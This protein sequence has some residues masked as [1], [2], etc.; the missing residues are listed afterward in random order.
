M[1]YTQLHHPFKGLIT[2][3]LL[4]R[5]VQNFHFQWCEMMSAWPS[6][7]L[8]FQRQITIFDS[9]ESSFKSSKV[10]SSP[11]VCNQSSLSSLT[12]EWDLTSPVK[13]I[14]PHYFKLWLL[15]LFDSRVTSCKSIKVYL[16]TLFAAMALNLVF[17][18]ASILLALS[19]T[20]LVS[21]VCPVDKLNN[22]KK[23]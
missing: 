10:L 3:S 19:H 17:L 5:I 8:M 4:V 15:I 2:P 9:G 23:E 6:G 11:I 20:S 18:T 1:R 22:L 21:D 16:A 14:K 7:S 12:W 13:S